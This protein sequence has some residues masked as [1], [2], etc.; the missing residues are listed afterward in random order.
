MGSQNHRFEFRPKKTNT[1]DENP[2]GRKIFKPKQMFP[3][4]R[5]LIFYDDDDA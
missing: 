4:V 1:N 5:R 2:R 3:N